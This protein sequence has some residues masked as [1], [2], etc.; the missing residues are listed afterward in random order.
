LRARGLTFECS[1]SRLN[2]A[3]FDRYPGFC[4]DGARVPGVATATRL[5]VEPGHVAFVDRIHGS[6]RRDVAASAG[7]LILRRRDGI[8]AYLLAVVIDDA[9]QG[10]THVVRG[11]DLLDDTPCQIYLQRALG[12]E[13]PSYAH[14]SVLREADGAKLAKS[15]R[16][17][18]LD[19][20]F[21]PAYLTRAFD[22]L[23]L[24][25]PASLQASPIGDVWSW[26][27]GRWDPSRIPRR[28]GI[29]VFG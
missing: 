1:C 2:L 23:G 20:K 10:I 6:F 27:I 19:A 17:I 24:E 14:V 25:P 13:T 5:R 21:A 16:S 9:D 28:F 29:E 3:E 22:L 15:R 7:D 18:P 26:G 11:A 8:Y 12:L 4:R